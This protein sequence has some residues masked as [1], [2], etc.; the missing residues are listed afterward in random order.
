MCFLDHF[1]A[2]Q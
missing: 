2:Q 1:F